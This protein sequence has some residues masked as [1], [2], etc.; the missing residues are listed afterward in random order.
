MQVP[1]P[2][3]RRS[4]HS[5][6]QGQQEPEA[7]RR[8]HYIQAEGSTCPHAQRLT[9]YRARRVRRERVR[10]RRDGQLWKAA[11]AAVVHSRQT[12]REPTTTSQSIESRKLNYVARVRVRSGCRGNGAS[13][14][15]SEDPPAG[16]YAVGWRQREKM[17]S[18]EMQTALTRSQQ[19][20]KRS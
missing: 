19:S 15:Q 7:A 18:K 8:S 13:R 1:V 12:T 2:V 4:T 11:G 14:S 16:S 6:S 17:K 9:A 10:K 5:A 20:D 3:L